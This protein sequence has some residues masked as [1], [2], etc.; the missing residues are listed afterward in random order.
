MRTGTSG[1]QPIKRIGHSIYVYH[2]SEDDVDR[3]GPLAGL[4]ASGVVP[5]DPG[6]RGADPLGRSLTIPSVRTVRD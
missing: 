5:R 3:A 6:G 1:F 2:L 4:P